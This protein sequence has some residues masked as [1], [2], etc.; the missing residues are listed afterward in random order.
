MSADAESAYGKPWFQRGSQHPESQPEADPV[1]FPMQSSLPDSQASSLHIPENQ[2]TFMGGTSSLPRQAAYA[3]A[4]RPDALHRA[5]PSYFAQ[6]QAR[7]QRGLADQVT[8]LR[9]ASHLSVL[10]VAIAVLFFSRVEVPEWDFQL[11]AMPTE[12]PAAQFGSVTARVSQ[13]FNNPASQGAVAI[14]GPEGAVDAMQPQI[15]PFTII[16]ERAK[17]EIQTYT[18]QSGDTVLA[19]AARYHLQPETLQWSNPDIERDP[20]L[21]SVGDQLRILPVDGVLHTVVAGDSLSGIASKY[22]VDVAQVIAYAGNKLADANAPLIIG[23]SLVVP[24]GVKEFAQQSVVGYSAAA[25]PVP[26]GATVGRGSFNWPASGSISQN[27]WSGHPAIDIASREG[28]AVTATDDGFVTVAGGG[29]NTGY[30]NEIIIDHGNGF[31]SL[32]AHLSS[33]LVRPGENVTA[34]EQIGTVGNTGNSTGPHLHFEIRFNG[35]P[36][37]PASFLP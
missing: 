28:A 21:L 37:N 17:Q 6:L 26:D 24:G 4:A 1:S 8:P 11:V 19:I 9:L 32:Y 16:P 7:A 27:Y 30:G 20:D 10:L 34:G 3:G 29:W 12:A 13:I 22:K 35:A 25:V 36:R 18:V 14:S 5:S 2:S 15:V 33:I 23:S 31:V